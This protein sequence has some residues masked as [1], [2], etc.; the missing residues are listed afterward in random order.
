MIGK[1]INKYP[2]IAKEEYIKIARWCN[3]NNAHI[4]DKGSYYTIVF[5]EAPELSLEMKLK[6]LENKTGLTRAMRELVA[7]TP[8]VSEYV[9]KKAIELEELAKKIRS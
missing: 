9:R 7:N 3:N 4:E 8:G 1:K 5:N 6:Q 2:P